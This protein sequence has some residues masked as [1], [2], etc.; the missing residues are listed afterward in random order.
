MDIK[1]ILQIVGGIFK[2]APGA[3]EAWQAIT[4]GKKVWT[5][6]DYDALLIKDDPEDV[7]DRA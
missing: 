3:F 2:L 4:A 5:D 1:T 6:A 7:M